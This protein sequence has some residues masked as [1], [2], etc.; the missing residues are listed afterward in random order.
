[1]SDTGKETI[2]KKEE[3]K[4]PECQ[5]IVRAKNKL[6]LKSGRYYHNKYK[7]KKSAEKS[8]TEESRPTIDPV[9]FQ[10]QEKV[11]QIDKL[12]KKIDDFSMIVMGVYASIFNSNLNGA[13]Q[14]L[15]RDYT[16]YQKLKNEFLEEHK[17]DIKNLLE[18]KEKTLEQKKQRYE[19]Y[20]HRLERYYFEKNRLA[21]ELGYVDENGNPYDDVEKPDGLITDIY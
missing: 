8:K 9:I 21:R 1:M 15:M 19:T 3:W 2:E 17:E 6:S 10:L 20:K 16:F 14:C 12:S 7:C 13:R 18:T 5:M 11:N 4:C